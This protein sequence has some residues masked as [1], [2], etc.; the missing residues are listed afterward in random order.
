MLLLSLF[1]LLSAELHV[2]INLL[3]LILSHVQLISLSSFLLFMSMYVGQRAELHVDQF[4]KVYID[5]HAEVYA[6]SI[7]SCV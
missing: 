5:Q 3:F 6:S 7:E 2:Q 1:S 4:L